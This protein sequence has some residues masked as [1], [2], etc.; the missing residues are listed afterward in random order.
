MWFGGFQMLM[1]LLGYLLGTGFVDLIGRFSHMIAFVLLLLIGC[2]MIREA[3]QEDD[4]SGKT[5]TKGIRAMFILALATSIDALAVGVT[6][7]CIKVDIFH[8]V[9]EV[10]N[11]PAASLIIGI[12]SFVMS[13][14]GVKIGGTFGHRFGKWPEVAGGIILV[15]LGLKILIFH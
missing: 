2:N 1:P 8:D 14:A 15:L 12:V 13:F 9:S 11:V 3:L 10:I 4:N 6:F 5:A 7:S